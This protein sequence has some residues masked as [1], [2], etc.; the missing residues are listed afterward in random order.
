MS[1]DKPKEEII[2]EKNP[3]EK[4]RFPYHAAMFSLFAPIVAIVMNLLAK[5][6]TPPTPLIIAC[7]A[8]VIYPTALLMG[9]TALCFMKK[10]GKKGILVR[11]ILGILINTG[12]IIIAIGSI[13][14]L[15]RA[16]EIEKKM[17]RYQFDPPPGFVRNSQIAESIPNVMDA[18]VKG[19]PNDT[20]SDIIL[21]IEDIK[22]N[23][24]KEEDMTPFLKGKPNIKL[25]KNRWKEY[26]INV[27]RIEEKVGNVATLTYNAQVP[28][29]PAI[30]IKLVGL[31]ARD[32]ELK[33]ILNSAINGVT[34]KSNWD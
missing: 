5:N 1:E 20:V 17:S 22:G 15:N 7:I 2:N 18:Y 24:D 33:E 13:P 28:V 27:F 8:I 6:T 3:T 32:P 9:I 29:M 23:I 16:R 31:E 10:Y 11:S 34:G 4:S 19:N 30:Q 14:V 21:M 12:I 25:L 26:D